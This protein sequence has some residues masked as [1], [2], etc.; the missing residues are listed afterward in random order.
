MSP[1]VFLFSFSRQVGWLSIEGTLHMREPKKGWKQSHLSLKNGYL[2]VN[3][4][5][6]VSS[7]SHFVV[8]K[9]VLIDWVNKRKPHSLAIVEIT[10]SLIIVWITFEVMKIMRI[11][12]IA[13][14]TKRHRG[15]E[16]WGTCTRRVET[17]SEL[18]TQLPS[19]T[20]FPV[21]F[22]FLILGKKRE[23]PGY[24]A[25]PSLFSQV[26]ARLVSFNLSSD[27]YFS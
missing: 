12:P 6:G 17:L 2:S 10:S 27:I 19:P 7:N 15:R 22:L 14:G 24:E 1:Y 16:G 5:R 26:P 25:M 18:S 13:M 8:V 23:D 20:S 4:E 11:W 21:S 3:K 9:T